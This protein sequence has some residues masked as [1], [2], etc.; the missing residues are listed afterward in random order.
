[1]RGLVNPER[2]AEWDRDLADLE[3]LTS[4]ELPE[5]LATQCQGWLPGWVAGR[6]EKIAMARGIEVRMPLLDRTLRDFA[7]R[8]PDAQRCN[9]RRDKIAWRNMLRAQ[10]LSDSARAKQAFSPP[11]VASVRSPT[12]AELDAGYLSADSLRRRGW[13]DAD[14]LAGLRRRARAGSLLA[15]KQWSAVLILEIWAR[16][17]VD[18]AP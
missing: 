12:F 14:A 7:H 4:D 18:T 17:Y 3:P 8:L 13:F 15:A 2:Y 5:I 6:H 10:G 16:H 1:M 11:A 9:G